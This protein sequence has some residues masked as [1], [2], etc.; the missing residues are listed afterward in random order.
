VRMVGILL[1]VLGVLALAYKGFTYTKER[2]VLDVG[3]IEAKVDEKKTVPLSPIVGA[4]SLA[5]GMAL[6]VADRR[7]A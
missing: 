7:R 4:V 5:A 6:L 2:T 1:I 3:P